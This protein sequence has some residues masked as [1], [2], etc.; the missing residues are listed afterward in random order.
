MI[1]EKYSKEYYE[2]LGKRE[3]FQE[4]WIVKDN[5]EFII[6]HEVFTR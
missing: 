4:A 6:I 1:K 5:D 3:I 2:K